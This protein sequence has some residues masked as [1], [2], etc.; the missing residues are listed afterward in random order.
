M[1]YPRYC[2]PAS[3]SL[4]G[5]NPRGSVQAVYRLWGFDGA[6]SCVKD[7]LA[8]IV[9]RGSVVTL[10]SCLPLLLSTG[11]FGIIGGAA[12]A[13]CRRWGEGDAALEAR[14]PSGRA[15]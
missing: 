4:Q 12:P 7:P 3:E 6:A 14:S 8:G 2:G 15:G 1:A 9:G 5:R 10:G 11:D 13:H